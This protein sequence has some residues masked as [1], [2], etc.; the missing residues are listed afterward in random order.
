M[1]HPIYNMHTM[2]IYFSLRAHGWMKKVS[3][4]YAL[5][6]SS[7]L[8]RS[9]IDHAFLVHVIYVL[10]KLNFQASKAFMFRL[11]NDLSK[12]WTL[13]SY[14]VHAHTSFAQKDSL[15]ATFSLPSKSE[16][17]TGIVR[18]QQ[19]MSISIERLIERSV[20]AISH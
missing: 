19:W 18:L 14:S 4:S 6:T 16:D 3:I 13:F 11:Q 5:Y 2:H 9:A 7:S 20:S 10:R 17:I 8:K 12:F 15:H 1:I